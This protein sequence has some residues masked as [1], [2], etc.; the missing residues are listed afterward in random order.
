MLRQ[1]WILILSSTQRLYL[2]DSGAL[3]G[4]YP[5]STAKKGLGE[6][7]GSECTP[8]GW[9]AVHSIIGQDA[10]HAAVFVGRKWTGERYSE[11]LKAEYPERDWILTRIIRLEGLEPGVNLGREV[12]TFSRYIYIHGTPEPMQLN[13]PASHGCI[14]MRNDDVT[15]LADW[16]KPQTRV[17]IK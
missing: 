11:D 16:V 4:I 7:R 14:R 3:L 17:Y 15:Q 6:L 13:Y 1:P 12:D 5:I 2:F 9:H 8:R 10:P